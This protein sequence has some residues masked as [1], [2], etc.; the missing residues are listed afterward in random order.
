MTT[1]SKGSTQ[2][3][4]RFERIVDDPEA[5]LKIKMDLLVQTHHSRMDLSLEAMIRFVD[6]DLTE[7]DIVSL[8]PLVTRFLKESALSTSQVGQLALISEKLSRLACEPLKSEL[9]EAH[10]AY[11]KCFGANIT[12]EYDI[13]QQQ[14][15]LAG[16]FDAESYPD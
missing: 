7:Y 13:L 6:L 8:A 10:Q 9:L 12:R 2:P 3:L 16:D 5:L 14:E 4:S 15:Y 11:A 1:E